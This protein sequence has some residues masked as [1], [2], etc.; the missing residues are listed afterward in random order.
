MIPAYICKIIPRLPSLKNFLDPFLILFFLIS[1]CHAEDIENKE[2]TLVSSIINAYGGKEQ[3]SN[4]VSILAEGHIKNFFDKDEGTYFRYMKRERKLFVDIKYSR[5]EEKRILIGNKGYRGTGRKV[6]EVKGAPYDAMVYQYNQLDL[7][8][9]LIDNTFKVTYLRKDS[10]GSVD[11]DVLKLLDK[12]GHNID[13][14]VGAKDFL[15]LKVVGT[16]GSG[17]STTSLAA[18]FSDYKK[19]DG[20]LLPFKITNYA[21]TAKISETEITKYSINPTIDDSAYFSVR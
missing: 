3:L 7:P 16:F 21:D 10:F 17:D 15:I 6:S 5:L 12:A 2:K 11:A 1:L 13:V 19:L 20:I 8:Y 9:G 14:Y 18:E 4:V